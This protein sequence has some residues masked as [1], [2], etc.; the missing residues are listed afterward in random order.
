MYHEPS[1]SKMAWHFSPTE[2]VR[3]STSLAGALSDDL[4]CPSSPV[5]SI[6]SSRSLR[7]VVHSRLPGSWAI[8]AS[9]WASCEA[10]KG[11]WWEEVKR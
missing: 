2:Y 6:T 5:S 3:S 4:I 1:I 7:S 10:R 9:T 8:A 11:R